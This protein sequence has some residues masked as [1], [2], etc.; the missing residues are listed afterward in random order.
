MRNLHQIPTVQEYP[1]QEA[2]A[3]HLQ[4]LHNKL[5]VGLQDKQHFQHCFYLLYFLKN[6]GQVGNQPLQEGTK[7]LKKSPYYRKAQKFAVT[8]A[9]IPIKE[10][11]STTT[12]AAPQAGELHGVDCNGLYHDVNKILSTLHQ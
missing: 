3:P 6:P 8:S 4:I 12:V 10:Y 7:H 5:Q 2:Q 9:T 11:I 1:N